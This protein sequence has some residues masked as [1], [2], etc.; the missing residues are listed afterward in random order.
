MRKDNA[1]VIQEYLALFSHLISF[2]D[3][4]LRTHLDEIGFHPELYAIP[5][6]LTMYTHVFPLQKI[7]HLWDTLLLGTSSYPLLIGVAILQQLRDALLNFGFNDCILLFSDLP[8][9]DIQRCLQ[10]SIRLFCATPKSVVH[11]TYGNPSEEKVSTGSEDHILIPPSQRKIPEGRRS[12]SDIDL[13]IGP[14]TL[15]ELKRDISPK[16]SAREFL[17]LQRTGNFQVLDVRQVEEFQRGSVSEAL[18]F[19]YPSCLDS[20]GHLSPSAQRDKLLDTVRSKNRIYVVLGP[21]GNEYA[22][23]FAETLVHSG[24]PRVC[25]LHGGVEVLRT[26][27]VLVIPSPTS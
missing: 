18:N 3:P 25:I 1:L 9:I 23:M 12:V 7:F 27:G 20:S 8:D 21:R 14:R 22:S 10:D 24:I 4:V 16:I 15:A 5:W 17:E 19:P 2:H 13:D 11:R 26:S 6:F